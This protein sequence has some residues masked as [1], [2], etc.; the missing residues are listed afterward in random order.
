M[1]PAAKTSTTGAGR[2]ARRARLVRC[3]ERLTSPQQRV[4][5]EGNGRARPTLPG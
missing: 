5:T 4:A 3:L 2:S 1:D